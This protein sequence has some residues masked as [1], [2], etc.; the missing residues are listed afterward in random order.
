MSLE[1]YLDNAATTRPYRQVVDLMADVAY[2]HWGN[3]SSTYSLGDDTRQIIEKVRKQIANDI[4]SDPSE[5]IFTS[6]ACEANSLAYMAG[7]YR[8]KVSSKLEHKSLELINKDYARLVENDEFGRI[9]L[10]SLYNQ[11]TG[12]YNANKKWFVTIQAANGEIG[13]IQNIKELSDLAHDFDVIFHTDATQL[14]PER[15]IN[16]RAMGIDMMSISA[17]KF[18]GP[19]GA[20][21]LYVKNGIDLEPIIYGSQEGGL[22]GGTYN[23]A[24]I[25]GMGRALELTRQYNS[26]EYVQWLRNGLL[27]QLLKI[28]GTV[29]NGPPIGAQRLVNNINIT[30]DGVDAEKLV[31]LCGLYGVYISKGSACNSYSPEPSSTLTAIG[32]TK[33]QSLSTIRLTLD[34]LNTEAEINYAADIITTLVERIRKEK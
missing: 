34:E 13:V 5:I 24:A 32:L 25:A 31:T 22:R 20:G 18:H 12:A 16:V 21:F 1:V 7:K 3:P 8:W 17:Q 29:L 26:S 30:I 6:G 2:N 27:E 10:G 33:E 14:Y 9:S 23:T 4:N 28:P 15:Q 19:R 11:F